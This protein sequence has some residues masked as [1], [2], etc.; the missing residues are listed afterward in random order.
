MGKKKLLMRIAE[1]EARVAEL[2][3]GTPQLGY[4]VESD[5]DGEMRIKFAIRRVKGDAD[6]EYA[7]DMQSVYCKG[8]SG[9]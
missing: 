5:A 9:E 6:S 4:M 7:D 3:A 8:D 1:L 2:E